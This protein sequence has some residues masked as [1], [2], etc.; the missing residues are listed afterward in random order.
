M[1]DD[2]TKK[3]LR[4]GFVIERFKDLSNPY[5]QDLRI[6]RDFPI[7]E[8][9]DCPCCGMPLILFAELGGTIKVGICERC[10]YKG[11]ITR[12]TRAWIDAY[13]HEEWDNAKLRDVEKEVTRSLRQSETPKLNFI[14]KKLLQIADVHHIDKEDLICDLGCGKGGN[15]H[16]LQRAGFKNLI[17][18]EQSRY[19]AEYTGKK[20]GIA[21]ITDGIERI[22]EPIRFL[23]SSHVLEHL[24][25]PLEALKKISEHQQNGDI[26][27]LIVPN[28][29]QEPPIEVLL[30]LPHLHCFTKKSLEYL[31]PQVG[32]AL[33]EADDTGPHLVVVAKKAK[34]DALPTSYD[35]K[36][37]V[38]DEVMRF[39]KYFAIEVLT[40]PM[41][42]SWKLKSFEPSLERV[43]QWHFLKRFFYYLS[44]RLFG[45][46]YNKRSMIIR[47]IDSFATKAPI[48]IRFRDRAELLIR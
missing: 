5:E 39:R 9:P 48:E 37:I 1:G 21:V 36:N 26:L 47:P 28:G 20:Y 6:V 10:A 14:Q 7:A 19:R 41:L 42:F 25:D 27:T 13:Y 43:S 11:Y 8:Y 32:Y 4:F 46:F 2:H 35:N 31:L 17:G 3:L 33:I 44:A 40:G 38:A 18:I 12:P 29:I 15:L 30:W 16:E 22:Q 23:Y 24:Y 34:S 45:I